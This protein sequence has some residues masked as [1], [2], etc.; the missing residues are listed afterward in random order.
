MANQS[1]TV[2]F[3]TASSD[4][5]IELTIA[6]DYV[7]NAAENNKRT[8]GFLFGDTVYFKVYT[9]PITGVDLALFSSDGVLG[10]YGVQPLEANQEYITFDEPPESAGGLL[11]NMNTSL[12]FPA[13]SGFLASALGDSA[14]GSVTLDPDDATNVVASIPGPGVY[15]AS[16]NSQYYSYSISKDSMPAGW[17]VDPITGEYPAYPIV[18]VV[19]GTES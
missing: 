10:E 16:Y 8:S 11:K 1:I 7:M 6:L 9:N 12:S 5:S 18:I 15:D 4:D 17:E 3:S 14:C 13:Y 2:S 19:V